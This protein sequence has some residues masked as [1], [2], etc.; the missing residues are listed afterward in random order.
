MKLLIL[1]GT[2]F[3]GRYLV[4]A[5]LARRHEVTLFNRGK[6]SSAALTGIETIY[7]D[8]NSDLAKLQG[9]R[10]DAVVDTSGYLPRAV[11]ALA[12]VLSDSVDAY[13]FISSLSVYADFS[14][15]G[16]DETSFV[17]GLAS[18]QLD[19]ANAIDSSGQASAVTYGEMYGG[20][21]ALCEQAAEEV[22]PNRVLIIRP[23]LIVGPEDYTDRF[24]YWV[25]RVARGGEV[26]ALGRPRRS[27]Q[28]IDVRDLAEWTVRMIEH[29]E[30]GVYNAN[31]L[32]DNLTMGA[33]LEECKTV[34]DSDASLTWVS[35]DF[36]L[37]E[38]VSPWSEMPL[39]LPEEAAPQ[40]K[41]FMFIN[42]NKAVGAGLSFRPS[43][44]TIKDTL[45]WHETNRLNEELQ[46]GIDT[47][48]EQRLLRKWY[49]HIDYLEGV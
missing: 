10:W 28:F 25:V 18:E 46:A 14:V 21:K 6:H 4:T 41:G 19:K 3:V 15:V 27:V 35:D 33:V 7:G 36:L 24:T 2:R 31:G 17:A 49:E 11:R 34:T 22:L 44:D 47:G 38:K 8:R 43:S 48:K 37:Q 12:E 16:M 23:G 1:G 13:A 32:P 39:W 5:A 29:Q 30:T 40:V 9:R 20:L 42:C 26:L 45:A